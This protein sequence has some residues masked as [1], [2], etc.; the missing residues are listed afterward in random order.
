[1]YDELKT[2]RTLLAGTGAIGA[3]VLLVGCGDD[4]DAAAAPPTG[5]PASAEPTPTPAAEPTSAA[6]PAAGSGKALAKTADIPV[7]GGMIFPDDDVVVTQPAQGTFKAFSATCTHQGC[8]VGTV[9]NGTINCACHGSRFRIEDGSVAGG[10]AVRPLPAAAVTV[11]GDT[12][13][14]G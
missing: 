7:G 9:A 5:T 6:T 1:M 4:G 12:I 8:T 11:T 10:P 13:S 2:R 14:K 3:A